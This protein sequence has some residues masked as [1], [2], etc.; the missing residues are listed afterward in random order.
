[1][2]SLFLWAGSGAGGCETLCELVLF[3]LTPAQIEYSFGA[4]QREIQPGKLRP[5]ASLRLAGGR[6]RDSPVKSATIPA[7]KSV[8]LSLSCPGCGKNRRSCRTCV[9]IFSQILALELFRQDLPRWN[10]DTY[11]CIVSCS[12]ILF[13]YCIVGPHKARIPPQYDSP[14]LRGR[15]IW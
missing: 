13:I 14:Y 3:F 9:A 10:S 15:R 11:C 7:D 5:S 1:M 6:A 8:S 4:S 12:K 2:R